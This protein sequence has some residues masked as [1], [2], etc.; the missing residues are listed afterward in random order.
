MTPE[1]CWAWPEN[2]ELQG[3][4]GDLPNVLLRALLALPAWQ[5]ATPRA[6]RVLLACLVLKSHAISWTQTGLHALA[7]SCR[8][9]PAGPSLSKLILAHF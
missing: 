5:P 7:E 9:N 1:H 3:I 4:T 2:P 8:L 6:G